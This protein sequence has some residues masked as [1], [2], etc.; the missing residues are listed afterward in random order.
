VGCLFLFPLQRLAKPSFLIA[1]QDEAASQP[2]EG[3]SIEEGH[4][5]ISDPPYIQREAEAPLGDEVAG[6]R[7][8]DGD[9]E[10]VRGLQRASMAGNLL[11]QILPDVSR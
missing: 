11:R 3:L 2:L 7:H 4:P 1:A 8:D 5:H 9:L 10:V 6:G